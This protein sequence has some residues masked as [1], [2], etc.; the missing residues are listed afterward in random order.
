M[1]V[2]ERITDYIESLDEEL[3]EYL[4]ELEKHAI[5]TET[6]IIRK[7]AE[8]FLRALIEMKQPKEILE[9]GTAIGFSASLMAEYMPVDCHITTIE[10][11]EMRLKEARENL[12]KIKRAED[13]TLIEEDALT[14]LK[15]LREEG[16]Q[17]DFVFL[18][19][20]KGQYHAFLQDI[21]PMM[22]AGAV[23]LTDNV[24]QEGSLIE[25]KYVIE[26]RDR[27]IHMRMRE[28][29]YEIKHDER[30]VTSIVCVGD[31][32]ALSVKKRS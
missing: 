6:P 28:F 24:L 2:D 29:L 23:L 31:G 3:P 7:D 4:K 19:A 10:K 12:K 32:M 5:E 18:D 9:I 20:A 8:S 11:V 22:P 15:K 16:R 25:S 1:I 13:V 14:A 30:L 27:T 26:R 21:L 17:F